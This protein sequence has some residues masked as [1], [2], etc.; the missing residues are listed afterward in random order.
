VK[1]VRSIFAPVTNLVNKVGGVECEVFYNGAVK[2]PEK[3]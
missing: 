1:V 2:H 3:E